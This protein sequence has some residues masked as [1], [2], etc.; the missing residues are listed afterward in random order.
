MRQGNTLLEFIQNYASL[1]H[2]LV[3]FASFC[4]YIPHK[5]SLL[6]LR[7]IISR[8]VVKLKS[9][10]RRLSWS[11]LNWFIYYLFFTT[12]FSCRKFLYNLKLSVNTSRH[13]ERKS[14]WRHR[15]RTKPLYSGWSQY[16]RIVHANPC[17]LF[18]KVTRS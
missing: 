17:E 13:G 9:R 6:I 8:D 16:H 3:H 14:D 1:H 18:S 4:H 10:V 5:R 12:H 7:D 15:P 2:R 11:V